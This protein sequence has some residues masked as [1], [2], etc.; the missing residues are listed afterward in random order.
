VLLLIGGRSLL[1]PD[2]E[3]VAITATTQLVVSRG[4]ER[5]RPAFPP[6]VL[7]TDQEGTITLAM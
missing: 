5:L 2:L 3:R 1:S 6:N 7:R 4:S